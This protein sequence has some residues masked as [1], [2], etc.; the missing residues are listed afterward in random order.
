M[1]QYLLHGL[2]QNSKLALNSVI[3]LPPPLKCWR[4]SHE[5]P[6]CEITGSLIL[7]CPKLLCALNSQPILPQTYPM[8][9]SEQRNKWDSLSHALHLL[10]VPCLPKRKCYPRYRTKN[11]GSG[12]LYCWTTE[13]A[14]NTKETPKKSEGKEEHG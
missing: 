8:S 14:E 1:K 4:Y 2:I 3:G 5:S 7:T 10:S 11:G 9:R 12:M 6:V 13:E